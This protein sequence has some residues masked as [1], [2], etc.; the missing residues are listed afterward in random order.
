MEPRRMES[1]RP[2]PDQLLT[3][4]REETERTGRLKIFFGASAGVGKTYAMLSAAREA[5]RQGLEVL[6]GVIE[7]HGRKETSAL[8]EGLQILPLREFVRDAG[9]VREFDLDEALRRKPGLI[10]VDELAHSNVAGSRHP[11]R[12]QDVEELLRAGIDVYSTL[13]VQ[14]LESLND[15]VGGITGIRVWETVPDSVFDRADDVVL[16][17]LPPDELLKRLSDGKVYRPAQAEQ[18]AKH[19]FNKGNLVALREL[20]LRRMADRVDADVKTFRASRSVQTVWATRDALLVGIGGGKDP[21][22]TVRAAARL[23]ERLE[24]PW[25]AVHVES[26]QAQANGARSVRIR[27]ALEMAQKRGAEVATLP[28]R[29]VPEALV[30]YARTRNISRI[31]LGRSVEA[32]GRFSLNHFLPPF[33]RPSTSGRI[34]RLAPE[35]DVT[36]L[37]TD[38]LADRAEPGGERS[39]KARRGRPAR[40]AL[41][42]YLVTALGVGAVTLLSMGFLRGFELTNIAMLYLLL[43]LIAAWRLGRGP[44]LLSAFLGV[45]AF[46]FFFV[47]P[48]YTL[49]VSDAQYLLTFVVMLSVALI[50]G[51]LTSGLR[52][53][54]QASVRREARFKA[55]YEMARELSGI[56]VREQVTAACD[57]F[58]RTGFQ[59]RP[60]LIYPDAERHL[61]L[62]GAVSSGA[63]AD[64]PPGAPAEVPDSGIDLAIAQWAFDHNL[65][66][67]RGTDTLPASPVLYL[68]LKAPMR[69]RGVLA[70]QPEDPSIVLDP[71]QSRQME[72]AASLVAIALERVHF[73]EVAQDALVRMESERL[74]NSLLSALS[75]DVRTPL[76]ALV[77]LADT[78]SHSGEPLTPSQREL[79]EG[80]RDEAERMH[81]LVN[82]LLEM[83]R[84]SAGKIPLHLEWQPVE[85]V[86]GSSLRAVASSLK[87][88]IVVTDVPRDLPLVRFDAALL[89][90]V[91]CNLLENAAK[92]TPAG[93][94][95]RVAA[96]RAGTM[97]EVEVED[98]GP[99]LPPGR[100]GV[101]FEKFTRGDE[102]S[103]I[104]GIGLGLSIARAIVEAHDGK[105]RAERAL[106]GGARFI[107][108]LPLGDPPA[109][110]PPEPA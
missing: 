23:A 109:S 102:E 92:Y 104:P 53:Q 45:L 73:V 14:H 59:A 57:C 32:E 30:E 107:F 26:P 66:A 36:R 34:A 25:H 62:P 106:T 56:L 18:A 47:T 69:T 78:L 3:S 20:A 43:V 64:S 98:N 86:I 16:V 82:N 85:E 84:L 28:G 61:V 40:G 81:R 37:A 72:A 100:E 90:R 38:P 13:N 44:A 42:H 60:T 17:D 29:S 48:Q 74:R 96:R 101:L 93:S 71:S 110:L 41:S 11:K 55:L 15:I 27:K 46:D 76:T 22:N 24:A 10:L 2:D 83:A 54:A 105:I 6:A 7:T 103:A 5:H 94:T 9:T 50:T 68:P 89:E 1:S 39:G 91:L 70:I 77:G 79:V 87:R 95:L 65:P 21:E 75:H 99:G 58:V 4:L 80:L 31:L 63:R 33:L 67:G 88:H 51:T 108:T 8:L 52:Y 49:A 12:W 97:L 35:L 19:F